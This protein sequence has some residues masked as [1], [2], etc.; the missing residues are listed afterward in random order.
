MWLGV[1]SLHTAGGTDYRSNLAQLFKDSVGIVVYGHS[2]VTAELLALMLAATA[3]APSTVD[4]ALLLVKCI[5]CQSLKA[6][7]KALL[8]LQCAI[9]ARG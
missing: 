8:Y 6:L 1:L 5:R 9:A 7:R 2:T 3:G 4:A